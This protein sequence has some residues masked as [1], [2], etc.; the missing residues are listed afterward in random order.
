MHLMRLLAGLLLAA[1]MTA[2]G[3]GGGSAGTTSTGGGANATPTITMELVDAAG[4]PTTNVSST[5]ASFVRATVRDVSG[6]T[7]AG[8]VVTFTS[9]ANLIGFVPAGGTALT[10]ANGVAT[11]QLTPANGSAAG[12]AT[13]SAAATVAGKAAKT[14][15]LGVQVVGSIS[16]PDAQIPAAVELF[17]S[18]TQ[19]S[20]AP[21]STVSFTVAVKDA[22]NRAMPTQTVTFTA[23]SGNLIGALPAPKTGSAGQPVTSISLSPGGDRSNRDIL[24][25]ASA[26]GVKQTMTV[27]V[28]GTT[29]SLVGDSSVLLGGTT[30][31]A[32]TARDS[33]GSPISGASLAVTSAIGNT[34]TPSQLVTD[35]LGAGRFTYR[36][37]NSGTDTL[38]VRGL[39]ASTSASVAVSAEDFA[40]E[41]PVAN[42]AVAIGAAQSVTVRLLSGGAPV[43]GRAVTF[44]T[45]RGAISVANVTTDANGRASTSVS[46]TT[47]GPASIVARAG[48]SQTLLPLTFV[49]TTPASVVLQANPGAVLPNLAGSTTNQATLQAT[50]RDA[51]GNPVPGRVVNFTALSDL[52]NGSI[53]PGSGVTDANGMVSVQF[54]PGALTT[55][56]N[57][58]QVQAA[59]QGTT[60]S[61]TATLTVSGQSLFIS[62]GKGRLLGELSEPVYKKQFSVYVT[63]AN[64]APVGNKAVTLSVYPDWYQKG[65]FSLAIPP[66]GTSMKWVQ[67]V[68]ATCANE[69][70][71]RD[72]IVIG[73]DLNGNG[74]LDPGLPV[75]VTPPSVT[76]DAGGFAT[77]YLQYGKNF[78]NWVDTI[79]TARA[80]AGGTES[81]Q[82]QVWSLEVLAADIS[83]ATSDPPNKISPFGLSDSCTSAN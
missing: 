23:N 43:A 11:I 80:S 52:S 20:S 54:I 33:N 15:T 21:N 8:T 59:V 78:A 63:D 4:A 32:V 39:G 36:A 22:Q 57:G 72:G 1:L 73:Q 3:G 28:T 61:G 77:F 58:V 29:L 9:D 60:V 24:V 79:V 31:F 47:S 48:T 83:D 69:D 17:A 56:N 70:V 7:V 12:A 44:S 6:A 37:V 45:T 14:G 49:A 68:S 40:F 16:T 67:F 35:A 81:V 30:S 38:S 50:V 2:C 51:A 34:V 71:R 10:D 27:V 5:S 66:G 55:A 53:S 25:T 64:G 82:T 75:V 74:K 62:I 65:A 13:I 41:T 46:S 18:S 42:T 26:G 76:T 19:L